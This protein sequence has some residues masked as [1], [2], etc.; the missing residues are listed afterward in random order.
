[1][2]TA[3]SSRFP[4]TVNLTSGPLLWNFARFAVGAALPASSPK[5]PRRSRYPAIEARPR[6]ISDTSTGRASS[7]AGRG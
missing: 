5:S 2:M 4:W 6:S 7:A 3:A 1:M